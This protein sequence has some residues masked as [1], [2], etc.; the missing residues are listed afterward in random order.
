M[1]AARAIVMREFGECEHS[2]KCNSNDVVTSGSIIV[3]KTRLVKRIE[4]TSN[5]LGFYGRGKCCRQEENTMR[6]RLSRAGICV[7]RE[8]AT[9]LVS[10]TTE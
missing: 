1:I 7:K 10:N 8:G 9:A 4:G 2:E 3:F 6:G 5:I